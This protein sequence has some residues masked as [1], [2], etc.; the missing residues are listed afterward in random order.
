MKQESLFKRAI[1]EKFGQ[2]IITGLIVAILFIV[3]D[4][5]LVRPT[6]MVDSKIMVKSDQNMLG[7]VEIATAK[8][9]AE[10]RTVLTELKNSLGL[11]DN[12]KQLSDKINL[13]DDKS[14][15][16]TIYVEDTVVQRAKDI[17]D[18]LADILVRNANTNNLDINVLEYS[19]SPTSFKS[20]KIVRDGLLGFI[21][22]LVLGLIIAMIRKSGDDLLKE[23]TPIEELGVRI[24]GDIPYID[25]GSVIIDE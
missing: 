18:Q 21:G 6:Y 22:G 11:R 14:S 25:K 10:S 12:L 4:V 8:S 9:L 7:E 2:I 13:S 19:V 23:D 17:A 1:Q 5:S 3:Y 16:I 24:I 20:P 15:V